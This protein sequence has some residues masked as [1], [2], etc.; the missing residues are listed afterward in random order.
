MAADLDRHVGAGEQQLLAEGGQV[1]GREQTAEVQ[2]VGGVEHL[3]PLRGAVGLPEVAA[4]FAAG[5]EV[6]AVVLIDDEIIRSIETVAVG[7]GRKE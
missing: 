5:G 3:G 4:R 6:D 1:P 2:V 7:V